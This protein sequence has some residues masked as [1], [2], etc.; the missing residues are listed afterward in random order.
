[1]YHELLHYF[2]GFHNIYV[3]ADEGIM[4]LTRESTAY[5]LFITADIELTPAQII[6]IQEAVKPELL[7]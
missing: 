2:V 5:F 3:A 1:M 6:C 4:N 7:P